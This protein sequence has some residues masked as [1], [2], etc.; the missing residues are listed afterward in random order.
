MSFLFVVMNVLCLGRAVLVKH[1]VQ[2]WDFSSYPGSKQATHRYL[3]KVST[4]YSFI[5]KN[6]IVQ[7]V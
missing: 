2:S 5:D 3:I 1:G 6:Q 7:R 4:T